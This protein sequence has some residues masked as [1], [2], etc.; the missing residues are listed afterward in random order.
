[1]HDAK[2]KGITR[3]RGKVGVQQRRKRKHTSHI[4]LVSFYKEHTDEIIQACIEDVKF[5]NRARANSQ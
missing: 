3:R 1:M 5:F 4:F 2:R